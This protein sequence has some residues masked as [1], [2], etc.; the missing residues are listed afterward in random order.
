MVALNAGAC[1][2]VAGVAEDLKDGL[3][4]AIAAIQSGAVAS[5]IERLRTFGRDKATARVASHPN[6]EVSR[7]RSF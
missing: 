1:L 3:E 6:I 4:K 2:V 7:E 5:L